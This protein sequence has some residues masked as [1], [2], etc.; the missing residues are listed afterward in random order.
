MRVY[1]KIHDMARRYGQDQCY[2]IVM[3]WTVVCFQL[4]Y[5]N[6]PSVGSFTQVKV[7]VQQSR[8]TTSPA[9][10][11]LLKF[12]WLLYITWFGQAPWYTSVFSSCKTFQQSLNWNR[13][14]S[15]EGKCLLWWDTA[16][17]QGHKQKSV[18]CK[19]V[20]YKLV[21]CFGCKI[22]KVTINISVGP[23]WCSWGWMGAN[24][25]SQIPASTRRVEYC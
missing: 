20:L 4:Q 15:L 16:F 18:L 22:W 23:H 24:P 21:T 11:I 5:D 3:F 13:A 6:V 9:F 17:C 19:Y 7:L 1:V 8:N 25:C 12:L 2:R 14:R 10:K